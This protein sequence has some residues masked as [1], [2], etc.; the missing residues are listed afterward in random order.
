MLGLPFPSRHT[1]LFAT[2]WLSIF[3]PPTA[4]ATDITK[5]LILARSLGTEPVPAFDHGYMLFFRENSPAVEIWGPDGLQHFFSSVDTPAGASVYSVAVDSDGSAAAGLAFWSPDMP[6]GGIAYFDP[7]GKQIRFVDTG[8]YTPSHLSFDKNHALWT[9]GWMRGADN[10]EERS[11]YM[12]FRKYSAG[13]IEAGRYGPRS[14]LIS[15]RLSSGYQSLGGWKLKATGDRV[16]ALA[17]YRADS[18]EEAWVEL[19]IDDGHLIGIWPLGRDRY[20]GLAFTGDDKLCRAVPE[21][22]K[23]G[24]DCLDRSSGDWKRTGELPI[25]AQLMG[26]D[27]DKLVFMR[28]EGVIRL[29]WVKP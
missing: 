13:G 14:M 5:T 11:D 18:S 29:H 12:M 28:A 27:E 21:K 10:R 4:G 9:F 23:T 17:S 3:I 8:A 16:G 22:T 26:A 19:A 20:D 6:H 25:S 2:A 7:S 15:R 1:G 24:I